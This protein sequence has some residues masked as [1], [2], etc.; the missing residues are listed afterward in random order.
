[1]RWTIGARLGAL[2]GLIL[3]GLTVLTAA[4]VSI[5]RN[6][7]FEQRQHELQ[8][9]VD[10]VVDVF[11]FQQAEVDAGRK[12]LA[13]AQAEAKSI[14]RTLRYSGSEY[15]WINDMQPRM[16]MHP[17]KPELDGKD[18]A[19]LADPTGKKLFLAMVAKVKAEKGGIVDYHWPKPGSPDPVLK[20]S[21]VEG[22]APWGWI[23]G[24]GVYVD[25]V[26]A[27][28]MRQTLRAALLALAVLAV[29]GVAALFI[30]RSITR[31]VA[32]LVAR[33]SALREG[34]TATA[35]PGLGRGDEL[36]QMAAAVESFRERAIER[37]HLE[38]RQVEQS[39]AL[40]TRQRAVEQLIDR[41]RDVTGSLIHQVE[42][43]NADL[44]RT[45]DRLSSVAAESTKRAGSAA[46]ASRDASSNVQ[47]VAGAAEELSASI[48]EISRQV[49]STT[50]IVTGAT[51]GAHRSN[52]K[53][54]G[55]AAA[56]NKIGE[57]VSLIQAIAEQTN[58]LALNATIEAARAGEAGRG[59]AVVAAEV[60]ELA[61]QTS[62][63]TE[64]IGA[65]VTAIQASTAEAVEA[66]AAIAETMND[67]NGYTAAIA[68]AV[69]QQGAA[70]GE[71][72][73]NIQQA[74]GR[75]R[76]VVGDME[77]LNG[78]IEETGRSAETVLAAAGR[79]GETSAR[80]KEEVDRFLTDVAAA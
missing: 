50:E 43:T 58:L 8:Q 10:A 53:V 16:V 35:V 29:C 28:V 73:Q 72:S 36:G 62:K 4:Q 46:G 13:A 59:F 42:E 51:S 76:V 27:L 21:Y 68:T 57:V 19:D 74:A 7:L 47:S 49:A 22:F 55:L 12:T 69:E 54:A 39:R 32:N 34:D 30:M 78:S 45:A 48:G 5:S 67:V 63:A 60:K 9:M 23:V 17:I 65:Q 3:V 24:T 79:V 66:I 25:D 15:F 80:L 6:R 2:V 61:N 40:E 70:T 11:A 18:L 56:A 37:A 14:V 64:E 44:N 26:D 31:P 41:F 75:T 33:M 52:E 38:V 20:Y 1:M 77:T 71:I